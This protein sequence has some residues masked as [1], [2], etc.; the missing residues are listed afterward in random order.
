MF[1]NGVGKAV[2]R[3]Q[4]SQTTPSRGMRTTRKS[5][6]TRTYKNKLLS[7]K[8]NKMKAYYKLSILFTLLIYGCCINKINTRIIKSISKQEAFRNKNETNNT[9]VYDTSHWREIVKEIRI[10]NDTIN[11]VRPYFIK[12][13]CIPGDIK[14]KQYVNYI[15]FA[16]KEVENAKKKLFNNLVNSNDSRSKKI[17]QKLVKL[18]TIKDCEFKPIPFY[19]LTYNIIDISKGQ[20][21][22][23][24]FTL[25]TCIN[26]IVYQVFKNNIY[27]CSIRYNTLTSNTKIYNSCYPTDLFVEDSLGYKIASTQSEFPIAL[28][29]SKIP[30]NGISTAKLFDS[31]GFVVGDDLLIASGRINY[32]IRVNLETNKIIEA[33]IE[34]TKKV[35]SLNKELFNS[36]LVN[37]NSEHYSIKLISAL[38]K[39]YSTLIN[40]LKIANLH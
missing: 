40:S 21:V 32:P 22:I 39:G 33:K 5:R 4:E 2:R 27:M 18:E 9:I 15:N 31:Y 35:V 24:Y 29:Y 11:F 17:V 26:H 1:N 12:E 36:I 19:F 38:N 7:N 20:S 13:L 34:V 16:L 23:K 37:Q 30:Y 28:L 8:H 14:N 10:G 6:T 3:V 25:D